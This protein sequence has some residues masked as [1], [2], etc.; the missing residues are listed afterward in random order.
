MMHGQVKG[1]D[2]IREVC[3]AMGSAVTLKTADAKDRL[4]TTSEM[5]AF[6]RGLD[7]YVCFSSSEGTCVPLL[8]AAAS[9][10]AI[11]STDVGVAAALVS[12][13]GGRCGQI[14]ERT[15][16]A[17]TEALAWCTENRDGLRKQGNAARRTIEADGWDWSNRAR[18]YRQVIVE[19]REGECE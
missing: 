1:L 19:A 11:V 5:A 13:S 6:Y 10:V 16:E 15:P 7:V 17:L 4:R 9:G 8:E 2:T 18:A 12:G 3:D 14:I